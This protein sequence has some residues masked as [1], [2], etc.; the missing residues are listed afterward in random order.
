MRLPPTLLK[1]VREKVAEAAMPYQRF[2]RA[3]L[4]QA[5]SGKK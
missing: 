5:V 1:A 4:E 3:A 2:I